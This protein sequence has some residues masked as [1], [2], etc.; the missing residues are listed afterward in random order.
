MTAARRH[1]P[2]W[3]LLVIVAVIVAVLIILAVG[4]WLWFKL[5]PVTIVEPPPGVSAL[6]TQPIPDGPN[7]DLIRRG[8]YLASAGDCMSCHTR[9]GGHP[10]AG[11]LGLQTPFGIIYSSNITGDRATGIGGW[12]P[13]QFYRALH[14]GRRNDGGWLYPAMPYNHFTVMT[15]ADTDAILAFLKTVPA[16][17]YSQPADRLPFPLDIRLAMIG[18]NALN[19]SP[20]GFKSDP[21]QSAAWNRGAYLVQG[22]GHCG[23]CHTAKTALGAEKDGHALQGGPVEHWF[24]PDLTGNP[25]TGLGRWSAADIVEY[26]RTGRNAH[27]GA[28][29]Q[30]AEVVTY[31][32]SL[33]S[34]GDLNA[35]A[36]YLKSLPA[37][38]DEATAAPAAAA[39]K[40]GG[41]VFFDACTACH[42][43]DGKGQ[44]RM[45]PPLQGSAV[46]QQRDPTG[47]IRLIL[48]GGRTAPTLT[49]PGFQTMPSFAWKLDDQQIADVATYV[50]NSWGNRAAP[51]DAKEVS[52]IRSTLHLRPVLGRES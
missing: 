13:A 34:D 49:R 51:V 3:W 10:F 17:H 21:G 26:L 14:E 20:H 11:G 41:A 30:M 5:N 52:K 22:P 15:R 28:I 25:R 39:M 46:A 19:F 48:S 2:G 16:E 24:A 29:G 36:T 42:L 38:P 9:A 35:I 7:A 23:A 8:R 40:A 31:S 43:V 12:T 32:T 45:F 1:S 44:P 47:V 6:L 33:L 50:R 4:S 18:W 37:S 27:A